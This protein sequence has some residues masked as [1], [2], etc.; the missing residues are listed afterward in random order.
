MMIEG[1]NEKY[2]QKSYGNKQTAMGLDIKSL[3]VFL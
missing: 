3:K 1:F 2:I